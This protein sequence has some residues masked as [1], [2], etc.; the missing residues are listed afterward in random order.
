VA[1]TDHEHDTYVVDVTLHR[2]T[3]TFSVH[4]PTT[5]QDFGFTYLT[6]YHFFKEAI[7]LHNYLYPEE[8]IEP[9]FES[10]TLISSYRN[11]HAF[12]P[13]IS[14]SAA[15][16]GSSR[17]DHFRMSL[18][19]KHLPRYQFS[20]RHRTRV[21]ASPEEVIRAVI[22]FNRPRDR[23]SDILLALRTVPSRLMG[24]E[25]PLVGKP[26]FT[27]LDQDEKSET[28]AGLIGRFWQLD[29]GLVPI[30]DADAFAHFAEPGTPKLVIG[31][32]VAPDPVGTLLTTETRVFC[33]DRYSLLR[34]APY[35]MLI[36]IP[37]GLIRRRTLR[38]IKAAAEK[39]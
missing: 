30:P 15:H 10:F 14:L 3:G 33:P 13:S 22:N 37:S 25:A 26:I 19:D 2:E 5:A 31:Y 39:T 8:A 11:Y 35:W 12:Q 16:P 18:I 32:R 27:P 1:L 4:S 36:R 24:R 9:L 28:V 34:F 20:E 23:F 38:A 29:G 6:D 7:S 21:K 17:L